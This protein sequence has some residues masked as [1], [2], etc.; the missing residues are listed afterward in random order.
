MLSI[1]DKVFNEKQEFVAKSIRGMQKDVQGLQHKLT[2]LILSEYA[3]LFEVEKGIL[4]DS[5]ANYNLLGKMDKVFNTFQANFQNDVLSSYANNVAKTAVMNG[6]Y[7]TAMGFQESVIKGIAKNKFN[8]QEKLGI[9]PKGFLKKDGYLYQLGQTP[10]VRSQLRNYVVQNIANQTPYNQYLKGFE[11]LINGST[12]T[13]GALEKYYDQYAYDTFNQVDASVNKQYAEN[14]D[15]HHFLYAGSII[16]TSRD[17]CIKRA[18]KVFT[19]DWKNDSTLPVSKNWP[20]ETYK[21]LIERGRWRCR[22]FI[23][24]ISLELYNQLKA[25]QQ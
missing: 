16:E 6:N 24:Y 8:L 3:P 18:G 12:G 7:Y 14:L 20:K 2:E 13:N 15:L 21:P 10:E 4:L 1:A 17:F 22:H 23:K 25:N 5:P 19:T 9:T 11:N